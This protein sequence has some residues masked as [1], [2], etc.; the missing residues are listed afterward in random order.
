MTSHFV[1]AEPLAKAPCCDR[2]YWKAKG[3]EELS[4]ACQRRGKTPQRL[5]PSIFKSLTVNLAT[6]N[7]IRPGGEKF[8]LWR[9]AVTASIKEP[10]AFW[11]NGSEGKKKSYNLYVER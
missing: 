6:S 7:A 10:P 1:F 11:V 9:L 8:L 5:L 4:K 3:T 2:N